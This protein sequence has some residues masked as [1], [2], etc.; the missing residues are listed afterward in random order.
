M[1]MQVYYVAFLCPCILTTPLGRFGTFC[2]THEYILR[3]ECSAM[4]LSIRWSSWQKNPPLLITSEVH[5]HWT[6]SAF[7]EVSENGSDQLNR[8]HWLPSVIHSSETR[9]YFFL[10]IFF[11]SLL[12][13]F[14]KLFTLRRKKLLYCIDSFVVIN[15]F[16]TFTNG[17]FPVDRLIV[18]ICLVS[19]LTSWF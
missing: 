19:N 11:W 2:S 13:K 10:F 8:K 15:L 12:P 4:Y 17:Y 6:L 16:I 5:R 3:F 18:T 7:P 9:H 14:N 1:T